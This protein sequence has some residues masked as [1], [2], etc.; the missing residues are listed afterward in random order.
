MR[1]PGGINH[2]LQ[3]AAPVIP[4]NG[5]IIAQAIDCHRMGPV[6][7]VNRASL[8][9]DG[10]NGMIYE[11]KLP[12]NSSPADVTSST[13][14]PLHHKPVAKAIHPLNQA[15]NAKWVPINK[16]FITLTRIILKS[17]LER[18]ALVNLAI[19][20]RC[21]TQQGYRHLILVNDDRDI[22]IAAVGRVEEFII[23]T[24]MPMTPPAER[25]NAAEAVTFPVDFQGQ[26]LGYLVALVRNA[27]VD[28]GDEMQDH[29]SASDIR[30]RLSRVAE[31][32]VGVIKR[33]QTRY[34]AIYVY[35]DQCYWIGNSAALR[36]LDHRIDTLASS[37]LPILIR[38]NK[39]AGKIIAARALHCERHTD[40]V[41][42]IES[43]CHEWQE[44]AAT[45]ILQALF[46]YAKGGTL[47]LRSVDKLSG[48]NLQVLQA[49]CTQ[50][51]LEKTTKGH[52][53]SV[54]IIFSLSRR[55]AE[56]P[57]SLQRW[58][59]INTVDL[60]L[61]DL[62]E[63]QEDIRDLTRFFI[64]ECALG[65]EFDLTESAWQQL[66]TFPWTDNV[67]GLKRLI[68]QLSARAEHPLV[69]RPLLESLMASLD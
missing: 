10:N 67:E 49:F 56:L 55:D 7:P 14:K 42:F 34:R 52:A 13:H 41:P 16:S 45:S 32:M 51:T 8:V 48:E 27:R 59:S 11:P 61:P 19:T 46:A 21:V 20:L 3:T 65:K 18:F 5:Q 25:L 39:G 28:P 1:K 26:R 12:A 60:Y 2:D 33:Y 37:A 9:F 15:A 53:E 69:D 66:E 36:Q 17:A 63:R 40:I 62:R 64:R 57:A 23:S 29:P 6:S 4:C 68:V 35:G 54:D 44:D 47:F 38:G 50:R 30:Y 58:L 43:G 22:Q 24:E 31:E